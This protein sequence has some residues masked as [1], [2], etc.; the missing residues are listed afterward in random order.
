M[1]EDDDSVFGR[2]QG[3]LVL[4]V[5]VTPKQA[6]KSHD[7]L[8]RLDVLK[9]MFEVSCGPLC[10]NQPL[11]SANE[12]Q[13]SINRILAYSY[14]THVG[15]VSIGTKP[16]LAMGLS[17]VLEN[18]RAHVNNMRAEGDTAL[19]DALALARDQLVEYGKKY[20]SAKKRIIC[21]SDGV[22]TK[23]ATNTAQ[24]I[25][26]RLRESNIAVDT[27]ALGSE[28]NQDLRT[29]SHL[30]GC[31]IFRPNSLVNALAICE[32]EPFLSIMER[33]AITPP[34]GTP[35]ARLP[36]MANF[37]NARRKAQVTKVSKDKVPAVKRH[38][39]LD[40]DFVQLAAAA[41]RPVSTTTGD[42]RSRR[43][44]TRL[45]NEM[46]AIIADASERKYDV[47]VSESDFTFWKVVVEGPEG[48][49][50][51]GGT[52]LMYL[53]AD[54]TYPTFAPKARFCTKLRHP[55]I[56]PNG[57]ICHSIFDRDWTSDTTMTALLDTVYGLLLQ[58]EHSDPVNT[59]ITLGYHHDE[60]EFAE[61]VR[62]HVQK[63]ALKTRAHWKA[64][65]L[66]E[67][68]PP[69]EDDEEDDDDDGM[70]EDCELYEDSD[71]GEDVG[72]DECG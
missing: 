64:E 51:A 7:R 63:H 11:E 56:N 72:S 62:E 45:M 42:T 2:H 57:R 71:L 69:A 25:C 23:S 32:L 38:P 6:P 35:R 55:N 48:S 65:L 13:A 33:P 46:R 26:W 29:L 49:P 47:Y 44:T 4:K 1:Y 41:I 15:L 12:P 24:D 8:S 30:L 34:T 39:N 16:K 40:D 58:P 70:G 18:F 21:I 3:P 60:V 66:G 9:Q 14:K 31:Y 54:E 5:L 28:D 68:A 22:D 10:R 17:H 43:R 27:I 53:H 19:W 52:F 59:T 36:F 67:V 50:Y 37:W 61:E 20:P